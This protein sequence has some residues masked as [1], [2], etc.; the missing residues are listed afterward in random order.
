MRT[1]VIS[2]IE[3]AKGEVPEIAPVVLAVTVELRPTKT[4]SP[5]GKP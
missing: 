4:G 2:T 1:E 3:L 5:T